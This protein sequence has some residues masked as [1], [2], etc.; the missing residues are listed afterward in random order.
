[1]FDQRPHESIG[2]PWQEDEEME[3]SDDVYL[4]SQKNNE[5]TKMEAKTNWLPIM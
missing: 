1:M 5:A 2:L 3:V 4:A